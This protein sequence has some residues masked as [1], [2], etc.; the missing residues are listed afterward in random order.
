MSGSAPLPVIRWLGYKHYE[1]AGERF[2]YVH[3]ALGKVSV[4]FERAEVLARGV[5]C[6]YVRV[7]NAWRLE[8]ARLPRKHRDGS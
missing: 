3:D 8:S 5:E 7:G 6:T 4:R 1:Y 2:E